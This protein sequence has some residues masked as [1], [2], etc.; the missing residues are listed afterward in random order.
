MLWKGPKFAFSVSPTC[1]GPGT[2]VGATP[3]TKSGQG[4]ISA[5]SPVPKNIPGRW[6]SKRKDGISIHLSLHRPCEERENPKVLERIF[7]L[8]S[9]NE[10]LASFKTVSEDRTFAGPEFSRISILKCW[11]LLP[12]DSFILTSSFIL[13]LDQCIDSSPI[14]PSTEWQE[15]QC[16]GFYSFHKVSSIVKSVFL[17]LLTQRQNIPEVSRKLWPS[18]GSNVCVQVLWSFGLGLKVCQSKVEV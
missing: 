4:S 1:N 10:E 11:G 8:C 15:K 7:K 14:V 12:M 17:P 18:R 5:Q 9:H 6:S 2:S 16:L 13:L 3:G